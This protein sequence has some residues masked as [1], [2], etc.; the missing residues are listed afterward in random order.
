MNDPGVFETAEDKGDV[1][2]LSNVNERI[3]LIFGSRYGIHIDSVY[4]EGTTVT[5]LLPLS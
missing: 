2:G 3:K 4:G 1:F 5:I